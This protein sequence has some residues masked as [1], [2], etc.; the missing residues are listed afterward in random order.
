MV[1]PHEGQGALTERRTL[2]G[3]GA[4]QGGN[5][6]LLEDGSEYGGALDSDVVFTETAGEGRS[7]DG[8]REQPCQGALT[9]KRTL[10]GSG[11]LELGDSRLFEDCTKRRGALVS[12]EVVP[13]TAS[14]GRRGGGARN[15]NGP[16]GADRKAN[17]QGRRRTPVLGSASLRGWRRARGHPRLRFGSG[18]DCE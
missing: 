4:P 12:D 1:R 8:K 15:V 6:R 5:L 16:T 11:A 13:E 10:V 7:K 3:G 18:R 17:A 14:K 9:P 2:S